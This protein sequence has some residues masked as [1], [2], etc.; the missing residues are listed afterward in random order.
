[1]K[2]RIYSEFELQAIAYCRLRTY[3]NDLVRGEYA[4]RKLGSCLYLADLVI[5]DKETKEPFII[6]EVKKNKKELEQAPAQIRAYQEFAPHVL[7]ISSLYEAENIII[8]ISKLAI[9]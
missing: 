2:K 7:T 5:L 6:I 4:L 1:M 9:S 8:S 3:Y